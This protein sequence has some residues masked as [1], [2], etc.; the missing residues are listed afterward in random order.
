MPNSLFTHFLFFYLEPISYFLPTVFLLYHSRSDKRARIKVLAAYY[1]IATLLMLKA[2][3]FN[4]QYHDN[5]GDYRLLNLFTGL[6]MC[7]YYYTSLGNRW[8][9]SFALLFGFTT[10]LIF[11]TSSVLLPNPRSLDSYSSAWI[12]LAIIVMVL[13][14]M[15]QTIS[16]VTEAPLA[17]NFDFWFVASQ[18]LYH[19]GSF[20]IFLT[21]SYFTKKIQE[22]NLYS[23]EN[24]DILMQLWNGHNMLLFICSVMICFF[25]VWTRKRIKN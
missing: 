2:N 4:L 6:C 8:T 18:M 9:K 16:N 15:Y 10:V 14:F 22:A 23:I 17:S 5:I 13:F 19:S 24:R 21:Y 20:I 3:T 1:F 11:I 25:V 7:F 12:S